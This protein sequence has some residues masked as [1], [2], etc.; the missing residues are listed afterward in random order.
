MKNLSRAARVIVPVL[1]LV[2]S[3]PSPALACDSTGCLLASKGAGGLLPKGTVRVDFSVRHIDQSRRLSG[4]ESTDRVTR[5]WVDFRDGSIWPAI[6]DDFA[7]RQSI[8]QADMEYG[9]SVNSTLFASMPLLT[10]R[11]F[12]SGDDVCGLTNA[13]SGLGDMVVG[14]R[15]AIRAKATRLLVATTRSSC[16]RD[17]RTR[18]VSRRN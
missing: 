16:P 8:M 4:T 9:L 1:S 10:R 3:H 6:H 11:G 5:P 15:R 7:G 18:G 13:T 17:A 2:A 12:E 14:Y